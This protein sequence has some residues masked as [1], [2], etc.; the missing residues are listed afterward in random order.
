[1]KINPLFILTGLLLGL[2]FVLYLSFE[3]K[4]EI[5]IEKITPHNYDYIIEVSDGDTDSS[6]NYTLYDQNHFLIGDSLNCK[7][8]DSIIIDDNL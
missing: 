1:M 3:E 5:K 2:F 8:L 7:E 4:E 6:L